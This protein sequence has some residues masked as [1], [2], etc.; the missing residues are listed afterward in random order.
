MFADALMSA[1]ADA[2]CGA[3]YGQRSEHRSNT[4]NGYRRRGWDTRAGLRAVPQRSGP[5]RRRN[6]RTCSSSTLTG[7]GAGSAGW[8]APGADSVIERGCPGDIVSQWLTAGV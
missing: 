7:A 3:S 1:S 6:R 4:R 8:L 5:F 2:V